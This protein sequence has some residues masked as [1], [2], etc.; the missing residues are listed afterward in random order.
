MNDTLETFVFH[1]VENLFGIVDPTNSQAYIANLP[2]GLYQFDNDGISQIFPVKQLPQN[3]LSY[4]FAGNFYNSPADI[5]SAFAPGPGPTPNEDGIIRGL[6]YPLKL[7]SKWNAVLIDSTSFI[8]KKIVGWTE[9]KTAAG[10]FDCFKIQWIWTNINN[11]DWGENITGFDYVSAQGLVK[12]V[13]LID[14]VDIVSYEYPDGIG[15]M[16]IEMAYELTELR[17]Q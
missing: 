11:P 15:T 2:D 13:F 6:A 7:D 3:S 1:A 17:L 5:V 8:D 4:K 14:D 16:D 12:R 10:T 9:I